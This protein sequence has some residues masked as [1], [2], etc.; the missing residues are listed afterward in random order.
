MNSK[1]IKQILE[2]IY[3]PP[4]QSMAIDEEAKVAE[5]T[6]ENVK[7]LYYYVYPDTDK[8]RNVRD[9]LTAGLEGNGGKWIADLTQTYP[10]NSGG[11]LSENRIPQCAK[12]YENRVGWS[13]TFHSI[14]GVRYH[15]SRGK[16]IVAKLMLSGR[17]AAFLH[18]T[19]QDSF[20]GYWDEGY[21]RYN[22]KRQTTEGF[23]YWINKNLVIDPLFR[24]FSAEFFTYMGEHSEH[25]ILKDIGRT[26]DKFGF[27]L[28]PMRYQEIIQYRTPK[29]FV[30]SMLPDADRLGINLD[31]LDLNTAYVIARLAPIVRPIDWKYL[32]TL[33]ENVI[34]KSF[35]L[36]GIF[37]GVKSSDLVAA[38]Y[39]V[40]LCPYW[41]WSCDTVDTARDYARMCLECNAPIGLRYTEGGLERAHDEMVRVMESRTLEDDLNTPL[42]TVPSRFDRLEHGLVELYP[43]EFERIKD[44]RRLLEEGQNQ[45][46]CV[47]SRRDL[48]REDRA[49]I[50]H[51]RFAEE[52]YTI[53]FERNYRGDYVIAEIRAKFNEECPAPVLKELHDTL[54]MLSIMSWV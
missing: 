38:Y 17:Q 23:C 29:E 32:K 39:W 27:F 19:G 14:T 18:E 31:A 15:K 47:F 33:D 20:F 54:R 28:P 1:E 52:D 45:H 26:I 35:T 43:R 46:N 10:K 7:E 11:N 5:D 3:G 4:K 22:A 30:M 2:K 34:R 36:N 40:K 9:A 48:V 51:W 37:D 49:A 12:Y 42:V 53:Q 16:R 24:K 13:L 25:H 50:F 6:E 41:T 8:V 21:Y 44:A